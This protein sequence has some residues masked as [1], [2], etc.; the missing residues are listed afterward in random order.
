MEGGAVAFLG[1]DVPLVHGVALDVAEG[2]GALLG[3]HL[4]GPGGL[5]AGLPLDKLS[6]VHEAGADEGGCTED[7]LYEHQ[8]QKQAG[9]EMEKFSFPP[10]MKPFGFA[11]ARPAEMPSN[12]INL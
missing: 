1:D 3:R 10:S 5:G 11:P 12:W 2:G 7:D 6:V 4:H 8:Q 9:L